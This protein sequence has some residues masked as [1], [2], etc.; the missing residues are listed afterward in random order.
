MSVSDKW[1]FYHENK[2]AFPLTGVQPYFYD[3]L[4]L[5][6]KLESLI[7]FIFFEIES[8]FFEG[9]DSS[10]SLVK[11]ECLGEFFFL[12]IMSSQLVGGSQIH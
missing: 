6:S 3:F 5:Q 4:I 12:A 8:V 11:I 9:D 2:A 1:W 10:Q 7:L